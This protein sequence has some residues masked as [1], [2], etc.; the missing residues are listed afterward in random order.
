MEPKK[1]AAHHEAMVHMQ[2]ATEL[3]RESVKVHESEV[4]GHLSHEEAIP[5][6]VA[7]NEK[8]AGESGLAAEA[9]RDFLDDDPKRD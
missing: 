7:L 4:A 5:R 1:V 8:A 6:A 9:I 3:L 2:K